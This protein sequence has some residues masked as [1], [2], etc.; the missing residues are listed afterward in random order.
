MSRLWV[1]SWVGVAI[2][3]TAMMSA[4]GY[5]ADG[6]YGCG[7]S[8]LGETAVAML[9][10][11]PIVKVFTNSAAVILLLD[12]GAE[13]TVL[14]PAAA[15]ADRRTASPR[16]IRAT[17]AR[18]FPR[19]AGGRIGS[20][21]LHDRRRRSAAQENSGRSDRDR[22]RPVRAAG[23][24]ARSRHA[25]QLRRRSRPAGPPYD[26]LQCA[27]LRGCLAG[28]GS[29]LCQ[30]RGGSICEQPLVLSSAA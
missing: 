11:E 3:T 4:S 24:S 19:H 27:E 23:W 10:N 15:Q 28:L 1:K 22:K 13:A 8:R 5:A 16:R 7:T 21:Q 9:S 25:E 26:P 17:G 6:V 12:T 2:V 29:T 20:A 14:T 18:D 30:D